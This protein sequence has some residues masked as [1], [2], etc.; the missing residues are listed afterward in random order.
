MACTVYREGTGTIEHGIECESTVCETAE[1]HELL[2][3]G[4]LPSPPGYIPP[5][6]VMVEEEEQLT[7]ECS[8]DEGNALQPEVD[9]LNGEVE[10]LGEEIESLRK[11]LDIRIEIEKNLDETI[12]QLNGDLNTA[13][14]IED[15]LNAELSKLRRPAEVSD[16]AQAVE[17]VDPVRAAGRDAGIDGWET[18]HL[19][20]LKKALKE[21]EA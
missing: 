21:L 18:M 14:Q 2:A 13:R 6:P 4:W 8:G 3:A 5:E 20:S 1:L 11:E 19:S 15:R 10:A 12:E 17:E 7:G 16:P 9:R